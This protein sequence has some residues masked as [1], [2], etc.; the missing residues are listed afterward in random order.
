MPVM[1]YIH[2]GAFSFGSGSIN[3]PEY[4]MDHPIVLVVVQYRLGIFGRAHSR[5]REAPR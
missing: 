1:V 2:G 4:L 3:G 5:V